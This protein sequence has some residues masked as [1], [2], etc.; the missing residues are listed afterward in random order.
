MWNRTKPNRGSRA[1]CDVP[2]WIW[3][4][5]GSNR[6]T[7]FLHFSLVFQS[8]L[9]VLIPTDVLNAQLLV[10]FGFAFSP[11]SACCSLSLNKPGCSMRTR[12]T[13]SVCFYVSF[14]YWEFSSVRNSALTDDL[15]YVHVVANSPWVTLV[16]W[17]FWEMELQTGNGQ[18]TV[19]SYPVSLC[20]NR[21]KTWSSW[22]CVILSCRPSAY[23][24]HS[25][26]W[27]WAGHPNIGPWLN[28]HVEITSPHPAQK[29]DNLI[30][31]VVH[32]VISANAAFSWNR[33]LQWQTCCSLEPSGVSA[34]PA[35]KFCFLAVCWRMIAT[36]VWLL[37]ATCN[38]CS[39]AAFLRVQR[40][41][42]LVSGSS[43]T[44]LQCVSD[45]RGLPF[46]WHCCC[47]PVLC[48]TSAARSPAWAAWICHEYPGDWKEWRFCSWRWWYCLFRDS[49]RLSVLVSL[50]LCLTRYI[51]Y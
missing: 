6:P 15:D 20:Q 28:Q 11:R 1:V 38:I 31:T 2:T 26:C 3:R 8:R 10:C 4:T 48:L 24:N 46:L 47:C 49:C 35:H 13:T 42:W 21:L 19:F 23:H 44:C 32:A 45:W 29:T 5:T 41:C 51:C 12:R 25:A 33:L 27:S 43:F 18:L 50:L 7:L 37:S 22:F 9:L 14:G 30:W 17:W 39:K 36:A 34:P 16:L 40:A